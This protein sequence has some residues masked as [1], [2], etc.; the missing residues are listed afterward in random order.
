MA[1]NLL[2][3]AIVFGLLALLFAV[4]LR[5]RPTPRPQP[6]AP[7][8][9][10]VEL[11]PEAPTGKS[12]A[13]LRRLGGI[14]MSGPSFRQTEKDGTPI[15]EVA[16]D[17]VINDDKSDLMRLTGVRATMFQEGKPAAR[18]VAREVQLRYQQAGERLTFV[19]EVTI[20]SELRQ[21]ELKAGRVEYELATRQLFA[22]EGIQF[23]QGGLQLESKELRADF[24]LGIVKLI[25]PVSGVLVKS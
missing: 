4:P 13:S 21:A 10:V 2:L 23:R 7:T 18:F 24:G 11:K 3:A 19:D 8:P 17:R 6:G 16:G 9:P 25:G 12:L 20:T 5:H 15:F 22:S 14:T 1:R